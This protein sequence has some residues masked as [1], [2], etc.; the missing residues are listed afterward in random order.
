MTRSPLPPA[1]RRLPDWPL[2]WKN[3]LGTAAAWIGLLIL[4]PLLLTIALGG[5]LWRRIPKPR[6]WLRLTVAC[7]L[8]LAL[9]GCVSRIS[10]TPDL[11]QHACWSV[12]VIEERQWSGGIRAATEERALAIGDSL[13]RAGRGEH[14]SAAHEALRDSTERD[15]R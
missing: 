7:G 15:C 4:S 2:V 8:L 14:Y 1:Y 6:W 5:W 3:W 11:I 13:M 9:S 12:L 10:R